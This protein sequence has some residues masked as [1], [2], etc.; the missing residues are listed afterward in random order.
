MQSRCQQAVNASFHGQSGPILRTRSRA[1]RPG[2]CQIRT[3]RVR[4]G[5]PQVLDV[6]EPEEP[7]PG[8][9]VGGD[10][11]AGVDLQGLR[12]SLN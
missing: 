2:M 7:G 12:C 9:E 10:D 6:V 8:G 11:P 5:F 4:L 1:W 3:E